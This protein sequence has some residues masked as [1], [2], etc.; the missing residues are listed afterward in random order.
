M[1]LPTLFA[2]FPNS[3]GEAGTAPDSGRVALLRANNIG[4]GLNFGDLQYVPV[5]RV[6]EDQYLRS[7]D[8]VLAMSSGSKAVV[9]KVLPP[10][11]ES[12]QGTFGAFCGVLRPFAGIDPRYFGIYFQTKEYRTAISGV[13]SGTNIN[14]LKREYFANLLLPLPPLPEQERIVERVEALLERINAARERLARLPAII[15][16]FRQSVL[17]AACSGQL[18]AEWRSTHANPN[19]QNGQ[20]IEAVDLGKK[21]KRVLPPSSKPTEEMPPNWVWS[22]GFPNEL[23]Q[24]GRSVSY[25]F[26]K[27]GPHD[28]QGVRVLKSG[29]INYRRV[30]TSEDTRISPALDEQYRRTRLQGGEVLLKSRR[31]EYWSIRGRATQP[32]V[33]GMYREQSQ[34]CRSSRT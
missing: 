32:V 30:N 15:K 29:S 31:R 2:V 1:T 8:V 10:L 26:V 28:P 3:K 21:Q 19:T 16:R 27:P 33:S 18:T 20:L 7:G 11:Q 14:N 9:G 13:A 6:G 34:L 23:L 22:T 12:W 25:G 4:D 5:A 17:A 24:P